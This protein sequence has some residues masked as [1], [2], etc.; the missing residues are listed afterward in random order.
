M[1]VLAIPENNTKDMNRCDHRGSLSSVNPAEMLPKAEPAALQVNMIASKPTL[2]SNF[3]AKSKIVGE[4]T[5]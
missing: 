2:T 1:Y 3:S 5:T 4:N